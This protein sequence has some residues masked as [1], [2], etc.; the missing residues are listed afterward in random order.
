M[1]PRRQLNGTAYAP[2]AQTGDAAKPPERQD[3]RTVPTCRS[4]RI[5]TMSLSVDIGRDASAAAVFGRIRTKGA[6]AIRPHDI[7]A[8]AKLREILRWP[9]T[10]LSSISSGVSTTAPVQ[11]AF[12]SLSQDGDVARCKLPLS[13]RHDRHSLSPGLSV[14]YAALAR[15]SAADA[16]YRLS[17]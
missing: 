12:F 10:V 13:L 7:Y 14:W 3:P 2:S 16:P 4:Q 6:R 9:A 15:S 8:L 11:R 1:A 5:G 17:I